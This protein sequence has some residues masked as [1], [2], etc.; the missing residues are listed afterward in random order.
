MDEEKNKPKGV[1]SFKNP[2]HNYLTTSFSIN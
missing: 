1:L 2:A